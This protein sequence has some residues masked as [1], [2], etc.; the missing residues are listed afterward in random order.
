MNKQT[1]RIEDVDN[2]CIQFRV[3]HKDSKS[4]ICQGQPDIET[5]QSFIYHWGDNPLMRWTG[6]VDADGNKMWE[7][8]VVTFTRNSG[9]WTTQGKPNLIITTHEIYFE[10]GICAF[11]LRSNGGYQ[12]LRENYGYEYHVIGHIYDII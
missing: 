7:G 10:K 3:W 9:D 5:L 12:K 2:E 11:V 8:D 4:M 1:V 6:I